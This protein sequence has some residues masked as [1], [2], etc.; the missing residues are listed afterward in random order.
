MGINSVQPRPKMDALQ[1]I[2]AGLSIARDIYGIRSDSAK[3]DAMAKTEQDK[4]DLSQG[5]LD[6]Q[7]QLGL[8]KEF[9]IVP[10]QPGSNSPYVDKETGTPLEI[11]LKRDT[12]PVWTQVKTMQGGVPGMQFYDTKND[13]MGRF[14]P[15]Q[16]EKTP[17]RLVQG[18]DD[19]GNQTTQI[20][21]DKP[22]LTIPNGKIS[23]QPS[24]EAFDAAL[25]G[26]RMDQANQILGNLSDSGFDRTSAKQGIQSAIVPSS[27]Q[28]SGLKQEDQA[29]RNFI[30][31]VLRR[32]SGAAISASEFSSGEQ[33][34]FPRVG[35]TEEVLA[36]K[37]QNRQQA[38]E[39]MKAASGNAWDLVPSVE[40]KARGPKPPSDGTALASPA[41][42]SQGTSTLD[43]LKV[44]A[45][46]G[47]K[48]AIEYLKSIGEMK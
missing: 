46:G 39:G 17:T 43:A 23:K 48:K 18:V 33:Q 20:V 42:K 7:Q 9:D 12:S 19:Q 22:G 44:K 4:Q 8:G 5:K 40:L 47:D 2:M 32:E 36:Q 11:K 27:M 35:D 10:A 37:E 15:G 6:K 13:V 3:L 34:Y 31:A 30:N 1:T 29:E 38:I 41:S 24:K 45:Q 14:V 25:Y 28:S 21:E 16:P 26:K